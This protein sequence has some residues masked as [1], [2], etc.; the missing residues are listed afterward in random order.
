M[1]CGGYRMGR[2]KFFFFSRVTIKFIR[3][4]DFTKQRKIKLMYT[5]KKKS[6]FKNCTIFSV[7][8]I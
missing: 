2:E 5:C 6:N 8:Q 3:L 4:I 1:R 7:F